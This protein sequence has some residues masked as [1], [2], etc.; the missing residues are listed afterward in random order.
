MELEGIMQQKQERRSEKMTVHQGSVS[1]SS[2]TDQTSRDDPWGTEHLDRSVLAQEILPKSL[3]C[4][5]V[6]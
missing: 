6:C 2:V 4:G 5:P 1:L 3:S